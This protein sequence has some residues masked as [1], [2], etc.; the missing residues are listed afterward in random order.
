MTKHKRGNFLRLSLLIVMIAAILACLHLTGCGGSGGGGGGD[1][2]AGEGTVKGIVTD[3]ATGNDL[4]GV[5]VS[6]G[7]K[8]SS[9]DTDGNYIISGLTA[10]SATITAT[11]K[12][13]DTYSG[14]VDVVEEGTV[15]HNISM[16]AQT[17]EKGQVTG[18]VLDATTG[19]AL[20]QAHIIIGSFSA[21]TDSDGLFE[22][23]GIPLGTY[24][25]TITKSGYN[26]YSG[27]IDVTS[28]KPVIEDVEMAPMAESGT[29]KGHITDGATEVGL[30]G[31]TVSIGSIEAASESDG[32]YQLTGVPAGTPTLSASKTGYQNYSS[33]VTV[34]VGQTT[35]HDFSMT[36]NPTTGAVMGV[37]TDQKSGAALEDVTVSIGTI[38]TQT[39]DD[40]SYRLTGVTAGSQ[41]IHA[42]KTGYNEYSGTVT[43]SA[44][45][46]ARLDIEMTA[47]A[48]SG[49]V[50][51]TVTDKDSGHA[52]VFALVSI[53][54]TE[55]ETDWDGHYQLD[56]IPAGAQTITCRHIGFESYTGSVDVKAGETVTH[57]I[58][59]TRKPGYGLVVGFVYSIEDLKTLEGVKVSIGDVENHTRIL[60]F[61]WLLGAREG[62]RTIHA[63]KPGYENYSD[64]VEVKALGITFKSF[65]MT[66]I[67]TTGNVEGW[68]TDSDTGG[69][70]FLAKIQIGNSTVWSDT[71]GYYKL[72]GITAGDKTIYAG[73]YGYDNYS[74]TVTVTAG[75]TTEYDIGMS[76]KD[77]TG[78]VEGTVVDKNSGDPLESA[79]VYIG[80]ISD[81]T[82]S[83]GK[84]QLKGV[85]KGTKL[86]YTQKDGYYG[87]ISW[88]NIEA[89]QTTT[90][91]VQ[92]SPKNTKG[93][94]QGIV[95]DNNTGYALDDVQVSIGA[96]QS[97]TN[98][99][100]YYQL[101][102]V[103]QG[104]QT[105]VA[106]KSGYNEYSGTVTVVA[107]KYTWFDI[108]MTPQE[109]VG[110]VQGHLTNRYTGAAIK[111]ATVW[112]PHSYK[113]TTDED[114]FYQFQGV[115]AGPHLI[116]AKC[117]GYAENMIPLYL[118]AGETLVKDFTLTPFG[119]NSE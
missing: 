58:E 105:I 7:S 74:G 75:E 21:Y 28:T 41:Q 35:F 22:I 16:T 69:S 114:G 64:T 89:G 81:Y 49:S 44:G 20:E 91:D 96:I 95:T 60:G 17:S 8:S 46:I 82:D 59:M 27:S 55:S 23:D 87:D 37:V 34:T 70:I 56:G 71:D 52:V 4:S 92:L 119:A 113:T 94:V 73:K 84:Y 1:T 109:Q 117:D 68:V 98:I 83:E 108:K 80:S 12:S 26:N 104:D 54:S 118:N 50:A 48:T 42:Q 101:N 106:L 112:I 79:L 100:G 14:S 99:L 103:E 78:I 63:Q 57:D 53:G 72:T 3:S 25:M 38:K 116:R 5:T 24:T 30:E 13:Y 90:H 36:A 9:T 76:K 61:Y 19:M 51:G 88:V 115:S 43:I 11:L 62:T 85:K 110:T 111:G 31:V 65:N 107:D 39:G 2:P 18:K 29:V 47:H 33:T 93:A 10:G 97:T 102:G 66:P 32:A 86:A 40:G 67:P 77:D 45:Q 6:I 15:F